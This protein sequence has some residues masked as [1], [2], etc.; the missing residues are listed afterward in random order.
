MIRPEYSADDLV[1]PDPIEH[2]RKWWKMFFHVD[3]I[4]TSSALH[5][6]LAQDPRLLGGETVSTIR[7]D[8]WFVVHSDLD[9]LPDGTGSS[10]NVAFT[11]ITPFSVNGRNSFHYITY[12]A[13]LADRFVSMSGDQNR[14]LSGCVAGDDSIWTISR[15]DGTT[16]TIAYTIDE[17][18]Y[19]G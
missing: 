10:P 2:I 16:R 14:V 5:E 11:S 3:G 7:F 13:A 12:I 19:W 6:R 15:P 17:E 18:K 4:D 9:W 8:G 1:M